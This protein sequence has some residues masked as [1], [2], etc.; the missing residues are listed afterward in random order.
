M[1]TRYF[2]ALCFVLPGTIAFGQAKTDSTPVPHQTITL[3][4]KSIPIKDAL[5]AISKQ[6][7][8]LVADRRTTPKDM[9]VDVQWDKATFWEAMGDLAKKTNSRV[10]IYQKDGAI[11]LVDGTP[12]PYVSLHGAFRMTL[13]RIDAFREFQTGVGRNQFTLGLAWEP[14]VK[15]F[16]LEVKSYVAVYGAD[17]KLRPTRF[18][19]TGQGT[20]SVSPGRGLEIS[21]VTTPLPPRSAERLLSLKGTFSITTATRMMEVTFKNFASA[22]KNG[23]TLVSK[24]DGVVVSVGECRILQPGRRW[25]VGIDVKYPKDSPNFES[26]QQSQWVRHNKVYLVRAD[27]PKVRF[28]VLPGEQEPPIISS[29]EASF[30]Y[31]FTARKGQPELGE[32]SRWHLVFVTPE[33]I[34]RTKVP[35]EFNNVKLP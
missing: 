15:P 11:A 23:K 14:T 13:D 28:E 24:K 31:A 19:G 8:L 5:A 7:G 35:F 10:S 1:L 22:F 21:E 30:V 20:R 34:V 32:P 16:L 3:K 25:S 18:G 29:R 27:N 4:N 6:S 2:V 12:H 9:T 17:P 26:F 33:R